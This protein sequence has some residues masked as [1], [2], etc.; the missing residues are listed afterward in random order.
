MTPEQQQKLDEIIDIYRRAAPPGWLRIICRWECELDADGDPARAMVHGV[1]IDNGGQLAQLQFPR[2]R[3]ASFVLTNFHAELAR[4]TESG[5]LSIDLV[6][7]RDSH[8]VTLTEEPSK[9]LQG[10]RAEASQRVHHYLENHRD[11]LAKL[12]ARG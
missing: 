2:P 5:K 12:A 6:I 7:D 4:E 11:E 10:D 8:D 1:V 3:E 9:L